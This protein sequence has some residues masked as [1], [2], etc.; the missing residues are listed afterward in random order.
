MSSAADIWTLP[1]DR[2]AEN[3]ARGY[4][5]PVMQSPLQ[6]FVVYETV[7]VRSGGDVV[8]PPR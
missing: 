7:K 3:Q 5:I 2:H 4:M 6:R 8:C 1:E